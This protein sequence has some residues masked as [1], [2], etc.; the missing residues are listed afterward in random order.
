[1]AVAWGYA[2]NARPGPRKRQGSEARLPSSVRQGCDL[3]QGGYWRRGIYARFMRQK[4]ERMDN[5]TWQATEHRSLQGVPRSHN[6]G[7][8]SAAVCHIFCQLYVPDCE[9][10]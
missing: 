1:M 4:E 3:K 5:L 10:M 6:V 7:M 8:I 2:M 9:G